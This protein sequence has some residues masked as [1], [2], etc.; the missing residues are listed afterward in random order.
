MS[1]TADV[2]IACTRE[3]AESSLRLARDVAA[4]HA[5]S[6]IRSYKQN[7]CPM[8]CMGFCACNDIIA[9]IGK[10]YPGSAGE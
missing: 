9:I 4:A 5:V 3:L 6:L 10:H 8:M 7:A 1:G 2:E